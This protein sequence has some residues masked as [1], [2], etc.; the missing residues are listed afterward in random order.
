MAIA[1]AEPMNEFSFRNCKRINGKNLISLTFF[2]NYM[3]NSNE[4][5]VVLEKDPGV[6]QSRFSNHFIC[7][8]RQNL[9]QYK[10][11]LYHFWGC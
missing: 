9:D 5:L 8:Q 11:L 7:Q 1:L 6:W 3:F 10:C 4:K 2:Y